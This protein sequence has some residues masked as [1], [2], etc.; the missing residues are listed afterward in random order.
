MNLF[1]NSDDLG[2]WVLGVVV[3]VMGGVL[4]VVIG[5]PKLG[6]LSFSFA[7]I[8]FGTL[9]TVAHDSN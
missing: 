5:G 9:L 6:W 2:L 1:T 8:L 4:G 3:S 7:I